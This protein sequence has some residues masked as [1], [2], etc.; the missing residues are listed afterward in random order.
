MAP[1]KSLNEQ[2]EA[3]RA[4]IIQ[5]EN[6]LKGLKAKQ[7]TQERKERTRRL[8]ERGAILES[9]IPKADSFTNEQVKTLLQKI[10]S[11]D[12]GQRVLAS[13]S[14][15]EAINDTCESAGSTAHNSD[16]VDQSSGNA[17]TEQSG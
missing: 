10:V 14:G 16:T 8:I 13:I 12:Y 1:T 9:L 6:R 17:D 3:A 2:I 15:Q 11:N 7:K 5:K 4:E